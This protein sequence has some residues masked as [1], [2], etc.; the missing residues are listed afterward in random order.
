MLRVSGT[1]VYNILAILIK[2]NI[3]IY[4]IQMF[5]VNL[6]IEEIFLTT[7]HDASR[8]TGI[9]EFWGIPTTGEHRRSNCPFSPAVCDYHSKQE[10]EK[11]YVM[12]ITDL[13]LHPLHYIIVHCIRINIFTDPLDHKLEDINTT[14][15][16]CLHFLYY[17][18]T[19]LIYLQILK[20]K[21]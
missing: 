10:G 13:H 3:C 19:R 2:L 11:C 12:R 18:I 9:L 20:D 17:N 7:S 6:T 5:N 8:W 21:L 4:I 16:F 14:Y 15:Y 1:N